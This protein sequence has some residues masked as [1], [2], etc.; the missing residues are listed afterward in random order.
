MVKVKTR[1]RGR[2]LCFKY[3]IFFVLRVH[4]INTIIPCLKVLELNV[5]T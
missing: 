1:V 2:V 3:I 5:K 4:D